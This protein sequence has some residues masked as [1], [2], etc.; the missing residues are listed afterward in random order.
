MMIR[1]II[2]KLTNKYED[3]IQKSF[4]MDDWALYRTL[5]RTFATDPMTVYE[6][7]PYHFAVYYNWIV[8]TRNV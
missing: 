2:K 4:F 5:N 1:P 7:R 8:D 3:A 6:K